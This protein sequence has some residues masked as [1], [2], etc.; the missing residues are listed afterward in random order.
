MLLLTVDRMMRQRE[1]RTEQSEWQE[2]KYFINFMVRLKDLDTGYNKKHP[3]L[4]G[5]EGSLYPNNI[6]GLF[7]ANGSGKTTL[8]KTLSGGISP[9]HGTVEAFGYLPIQRSSAYLSEVV[10]MPDEVYLPAM[11]VNT[12]ESIYAKFRPRFS[13][14]DFVNYLNLLE[15][16]NGVR[17]DKLSTGNRKKVFIAYALASNPSFLLM[18]EPTNGL[19]IESKKAFRKLLASFDTSNRVIVVS[20]HQ[21]A[22]LQDLLTAAIVVRNEGI[23]LNARFDEI[24]EKMC[25]VTTNDEREALYVDGFRAIKYNDGGEYT[26]VDIELLY[27]AIQESK[28]MRS[29]LLNHFSKNK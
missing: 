5:V 14:E 26:D 3:V 20:T 18:D 23:A 17:L 27:H 11:S 21:V 19:D 7:G 4:K 25:F 22:D 2:G 12:F 29:F 6:Y 1:L 8:L 16:S 9:L 10:Y 24:S 28:I 13:H 15:L